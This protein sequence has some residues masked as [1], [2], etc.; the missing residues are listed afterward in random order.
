MKKKWKKQLHFKTK[1]HIW[2]LFLKRH[3]LLFNWIWYWQLMMFF[4][5]TLTW[6]SVRFFKSFNL[7]VTVNS[8]WASL[9]KFTISFLGELNF[10]WKKEGVLLRGP[11]SLFRVL[12][13]MLI[14][15]ASW[16]ETSLL[17]SS[18][19]VSNSLKEMEGTETLGK[20]PSSDPRLIIL[21]LRCWVQQSPLW[22]DSRLQLSW[23][24]KDEWNNLGICCI[25]NV[26]M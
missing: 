4:L 8:F 2:C 10:L 12:T 13:L 14:T 21:F 20:E 25:P 7:F 3:F 17:T 11:G 15:D 19:I 26:N 5:P 22:P 9:S 1:E 6:V 23:S 18:K 16:L 24:I